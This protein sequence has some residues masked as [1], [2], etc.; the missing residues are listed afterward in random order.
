MNLGSGGSLSVLCQPAAEVFLDGQ[1]VG[2]TSLFLEWVQ[3]GHH[4]VEMLS[5][6]NS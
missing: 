6:S 3:S 1:S 5:Y 4:R 2:F